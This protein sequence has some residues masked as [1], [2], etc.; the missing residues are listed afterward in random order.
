MFIL[1]IFKKYNVKDKAS[2]NISVS[3]PVLCLI[4]NS[5]C[6]ALFSFELGFTLLIVNGVL[7]FLGLYLFRNG[8][9]VE[10]SNS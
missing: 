8:K 3:A 7:T 1:G 2:P 5:L 6:K 4:I 9:M 10:N